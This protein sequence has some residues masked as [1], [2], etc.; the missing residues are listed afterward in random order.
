M[1][2]ICY[3]KQK[4]KHYKN[5][6]SIGYLIYQYEKLFGI[7]TENTLK[8]KMT[9]M[10]PELISEIKQMDEFSN[11]AR[12]LARYNINTSQDLLEFEKLAYEKANPLK[13]KRENLWKKHKRVKTDE[14]KQIIENKDK[15]V[16]IGEIGL[17]YHYT[18]KNKEKQKELFIKQIQL[19]NKYN[20]PIVIHS[21]D[22]V[23]DTID[24]LKNYKSFGVIHCFSESKEVANE[25]IKLG[26]KLGIGGVLTFKNSNL[27]D[28]IKDIPLENI[29]LETDSPFLSPIR[30]SVNEPKNI[31]LIAECL[32][33][34]KNITIS[35]VAKKTTDNVCKVFNIM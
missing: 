4:E 28:V 27:K 13:S 22:A 3:N 32:S 10:T 35:E 11:Q 7:N 31:K 26:Y 18:K 9:R 33:N 16:A 2:S 25:Y 8:L 14:E 20:L 23:K 5:K 30:G 6:G 17:D 12:F 29:V 34:I 19:A 21:R 1:R 15:L 24:I